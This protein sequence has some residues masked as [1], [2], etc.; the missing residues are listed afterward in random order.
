MSNARN[1]SPI[2]QNRVNEYLLITLIS[3]A[4]SVS[5][6]R[7]FLELTGYPQLGG[8]ELH[9]AHVLWG[10]LF[11]FLGTLLPLIYSNR[12]ALDFSS[13]FSGIGIGLFIDEVGKF[14]TQSNDYFYPTAAPIIYT[15]FLL[16]VLLYLEL[17]RPQSKTSRQLLYDSLQ[18]IEELLDNDLSIK[19]QRNL[20]QK[21]DLVIKGNEN[22]QQTLLASTL[23]N[24]LADREI[25]LV[26]HRA[27]LFERW[28]FRYRIFEAKWMS[29]KRMRLFLSFLLMVWGLYSIFEPFYVIRA[30]RSI[31][32]ITAIIENLI[33]QN[34]VG[35]SVGLTWYQAQIG[36]EGALGLLGIISGLFMLFKKDQIAVRVGIATLLVTISFA[37]LLLFYF[38]QFSTILNAIGQF[39]LLILLVRYRIRFLSKREPEILPIR[40]SAGAETAIE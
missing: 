40:E 26:P 21:L 32:T 8:G 28:S 10:G 30:F 14:I 22:P 16:T 35:S 2:I 3:F 17:R 15:F 39:I 29:K 13:L 11:L 31:E 20:T 25:L 12:W 7:L 24:Y 37:N 33:S 1:R 34:L 38:D 23:K 6:T 4:A 18:E 19:E 36:L 5:L 27:T 9:I